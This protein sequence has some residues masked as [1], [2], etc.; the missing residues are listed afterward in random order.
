M[1]SKNEFFKLIYEELIGGEFCSLLETI[2]LLMKEHE[3]NN[4]EN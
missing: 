4:K 3:K 1:I 2:S